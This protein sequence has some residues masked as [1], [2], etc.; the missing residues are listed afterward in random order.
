M[1]ATASIL[2][3]TF[4]LLLI[5]SG[6]L[7]PIQPPVVTPTP[8]PEPGL[9][10]VTANRILVLGADGNLFTIMPDGSDR[11]NL[12]DDATPGR[13]YTQPTWSPTG[14]R[15][16]WAEVSSAPGEMSGA[17][18]TAAADGSDRTRANVTFPPFFLYWS[19]DGAQVAY[20]SNWL[21]SGAQTI[22][23]RVVDLRTGGA[24]TKMLGIG[25]PFYFSWAPDST[26]VLTHV[27]NR[28]LGLL[29][30]DGAETVLSERTARFAAPQ[31]STDGQHLLYAIHDDTIPQLVM[32]DPA[33]NVKQV[34]TLVAGDVR[35]A[36]SLSPDGER[37]AYTETDAPVSVN[38]FGPL[39]VFDLASEEYEQLTTDPVVAFFWSNAGDA[40][41]YMTIDVAG[42][43]PW[44]TPYVWDGAQ[45][46][47]LGRFV[48]SGHFFNHYLP[49]ADQYAQNM[50]FW[51]PDGRAI[52]YAGED[53]QGRR[54]VWVQALD[55]AEPTFVAEGIVATWSPR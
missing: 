31:W 17:L 42:D 33:G 25:Q 46:R 26:Q 6:C 10:Q 14:E 20:L 16:A 44:L 12:T 54:G 24:D 50:R 15:I 13:Y 18:I 32:A 38:S 5:L 22:A 37:I 39:F 11:V 48:P 52:V 29:R 2:S 55:A 28:R 21:G 9:E 35:I 4:S 47:P 43:R 40:L 1:S 49:F 51:S 19:P 8:T 36:F 3:M 30:L 41:L 53:E 27:A 45:K 23:L 7:P 34:V